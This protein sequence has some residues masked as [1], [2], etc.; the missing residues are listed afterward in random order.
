MIPP[1]RFIPETP[2]HI[3]T[4][5]A[6]FGIS[7][8]FIT[9]QLIF[10]FVDDPVRSTQLQTAKGWVF[11]GLSTIVI[12]GLVFYGQR[13]LTKTNEQLD[14][15]IQQLSILQRILR[16]NLRNS[17]NIIRGNAEFLIQQIGSDESE[18][19]L[20]T[21]KEQNEQLIKLSEQSKRLR[22]ITLENTVHKTQLDLVDVIESQ[23][24]T[25]QEEYPTVEIQLDLPTRFSIETDPRIDDAIYEL[26]KNAVEHNDTSKPTIQIHVQP[27]SYDYVTIDIIDDGPGLPETERQVLEKGFEEPTFHSQGLGL[28]TVRTLI[29]QAGG[30]FRVVDNEPRGTVVRVFLPQSSNAS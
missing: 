7:W 14:K 11:V 6:L 2:L 10:V 24:A 28:W 29:I 8:I 16:H 5:Y 27:A 21:I 3:A 15:A 17:C 26:L 22:N 9:D 23:A 1:P 12:Y 30:K 4:V 13:N 19:C 18:A 25:I 20:A